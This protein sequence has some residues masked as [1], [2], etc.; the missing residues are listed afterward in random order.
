MRKQFTTI[1]LAF[2]ATGCGE[3]AEVETCDPQAIIVERFGMN[4][5]ASAAPATFEQNGD[6]TRLVLDASFG[7]IASAPSSSY[8]YID[9][10]SRALM[11][12]SDAQALSNEDWDIAFKRSTV[13]LKGGDSGP[14]QLSLARRDGVR[15]E[16]AQPPSQSDDW[17]QDD[18]VDDQ[19]EEITFGQGF[20]A[21][22]F[23]QWYDYDFDTHTA[24]ANLDALFFIRDEGTGVV[25][26][27]QFEE[28][29]DG[30][31]TLRWE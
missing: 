22:A 18:F 2:A 28:Y 19:C 30:V 13:R 25:V 20:P 16:D 9:L 3:V 23:G 24:S 31:Y 29:T 27:L 14:G 21:T 5:E 11:E 6:T 4:T 17:S 1:S 26:K 10:E 12:L 7:G 15:W 8:A